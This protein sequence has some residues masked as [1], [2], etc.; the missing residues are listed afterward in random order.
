M[1][2]G[3]RHRSADARENSSDVAAP[4]AARAEHE[5]SERYSQRL[6][7]FVTRR[8]HDTAAAEDIAQETLQLVVKALREGKVENLAALPGFVFTTARNLCLHWVRSAA[9]ENSALQR[10]HSGL[11]RTPESRDVLTTLINED[12]CKVV[13]AALDQLPSGDRDLLSLLFY[14]G[15]SAEEAAES[16]GISPA[17]VRV[18]KH[19][20]LQRL[21]HL[22]GEVDDGNKT[23]GAGTL[24]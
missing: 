18:R 19:R 5:L 21:A 13:R 6:R 1:D 7:F 23:S 4:D 10:F 22:L 17:A 20:A 9:R 12:R 15:V 24:D 14:K 8:I 2:L 16:L 11:D 3:A